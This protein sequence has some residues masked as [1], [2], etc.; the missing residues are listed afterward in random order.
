MINYTTPTIT[1]EV[2]GVDLTQNQDVYV[3]MLQ[4][5]TELQKTGE[6][7]DI[8]YAQEKSTIVLSLTQEES[9]DFQPSRTVQVQVNWITD[10]G[11]RGATNI[12]TIKVFRNL[13]D[14]VI[15]YGD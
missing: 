1:L 15:S 12:A 5:N 8:S 13:L 11:E 10:E 6:D 9:A 7:L 3:T 4:G 14:E 2:E